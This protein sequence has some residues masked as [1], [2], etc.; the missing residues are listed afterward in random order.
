MRATVAQAQHAR[1]REEGPGNH[2]H[3][4]AGDRQ[5]MSEARPA[6]TP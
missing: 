3:M 5:Q 4:K 1:Q 2:P 6:H